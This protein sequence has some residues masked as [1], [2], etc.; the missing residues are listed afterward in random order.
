MPPQAST[1][2]S[3]TFCTHWP[4]AP[5]AICSFAIT[6]DLWVLA[7]ARSFAPVGARSAAMW[8]RLASN[9]SRSTT[10]AGVSMSCSRIPGWAGGA[11]SM[12]VLP[13]S[14][15][16]S[17]WRTVAADRWGPGSRRPVVIAW[18]APV[19]SPRSVRRDQRNA[20]DTHAAVPGDDVPHQMVAFRPG[21]AAQHAQHRD[22][23]LQGR[24]LAGLLHQRVEAGG[25]QVGLADIL[26]RPDHHDMAAAL[27]HRRSQVEAELLQRHA[28]RPSS[29][30]TS[31]PAVSCDWSAPGLVASSSQLHQRI[32]RD[33]AEGWGA[34]TRGSAAGWR[35]RAAGWGATA[36]RRQV[37][38]SY[39]AARSARCRRSPGER[40]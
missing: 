24:I 2:A 19:T 17:G 28:W 11:C 36:R 31:P 34:A 8:S 37:D 26:V 27:D 1:S 21:V 29:S 38:D 25:G 13:C 39:A 18:H 40:A 30:A 20:I 22:A 32:G 3:A 6:G 9:A 23:L 15:R 4:T 5:R 7:C 33:A 12:T 16:P 14:V 35:S 10:R